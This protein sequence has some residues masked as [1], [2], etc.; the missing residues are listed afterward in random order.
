MRTRWLIDFDGCIIPTLTTLVERINQEYKTSFTL[1]NVTDITEFWKTV[2]EP[3]VQ[4]VWSPKCFDTPEFLERIQAY[5]SAIET[6]QAL[7]DMQC[8]VV[9]VTDRP[10][11]HLPW[12]RSWFAERNL[13]LPIVSSES[14]ND[15][16]TAFVSEYHITT[17]IEDSQTHASQYLNEPIQKLFLFTT[18]WNR[19]ASVSYPAERLEAWTDLYDRIK[20]EHAS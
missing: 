18:P 4:W 14:R 7:L 9:V 6:I 15:N 8:P 2:P 19:R 5:P 11:R 20:E 1:D 10:S 13:I 16:K 3:F 17:V 12:V